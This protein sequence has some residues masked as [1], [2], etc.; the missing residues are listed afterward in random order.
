MASAD[1]NDPRIRVL[2]IEDDEVDARA[3]RRMLA[4]M[5]EVPIDLVHAE[6][7]DAG[8][9]E[10]DNPADFDIVLLDL[11]LP[12]C[13]GLPTLDKFREAVPDTPVVV[14]TAA[15]DR[16]LGIAA[17][18]HGAQDYLIKGKVEAE[19][20]TR[21]MTYAIERHRL[22]VESKRLMIEL[23][24]SNA[25]LE[26]FA[27]VASHDLM[28]PLRAVIGYCQLLE[29]R[30]RE[31]LSNESQEWIDVIVE[32]AKQM[33]VLIED[34]LALSR[35]QREDKPEQVVDLG[36]IYDQV[37]VSLGAEIDDSA[38]AVTRDELPAVTAN[39]TQ[40][41]QLLQN[42][43]GNAIKFRGAAAPVVHVS[44]ERNGS[45]WIFSVRD[46]GIGIDEKFSE[47][48]FEVFKRLH[49]QDAYPG[50]G[51]GLALCKKIV[52]VH[53]GRIWIESNVDEGSVFYFTLPKS[54]I[55][56]SAGA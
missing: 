43:I 25:E 42:L 40:M 39:V 9:A 55:A 22:D 6:S 20:M 5:P 46:N 54:R 14:L 34:L 44:A 7:L 17:L 49:S 15:D 52:E 3:V 35:V 37:L 19:L 56:E 21:A 2:L 41:T 30:C 18:Q 16:D 31:E 50:T 8:V 28:A 32:S 53:G 33:Q 1:N 12:E 47:R 13:R 29:R 23:K 11:G 4:E 27:Y 45:S 26:Q 24:R 38:A 10:I 48:V 36:S 51:I